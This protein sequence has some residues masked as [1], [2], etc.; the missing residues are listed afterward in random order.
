MDFALWNFNLLSKSEEWR[1]EYKK[2]KLAWYLHKHTKGPA[3][4]PLVL[5]G[6]LG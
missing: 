5:P 4:Q 1:Q 2:E 3:M 6:S